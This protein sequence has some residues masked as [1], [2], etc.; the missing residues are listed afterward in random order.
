MFLKINNK[1]NI[2][3]TIFSNGN[4]IVKNNLKKIHVLESS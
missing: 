2:C 1:L 3:L 4:I